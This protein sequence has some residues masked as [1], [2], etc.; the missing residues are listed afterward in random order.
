MKNNDSWQ[1]KVAIVT[2][3]SAG[4]GK[5]T[6]LALAERG[7]KV[8]ITGRNAEKLKETASASTSIATLLADS[9]DPATCALII[10]TALNHWGR[11]DLIVNNAGAGHPMPTASYDAELIAKMCAVNIT[12]PSLMVKEGQAA[13]RETKGAIVNIALPY[14]ET[15]HRSLPITRQPRPHW[16]I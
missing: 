7:A 15:H 9:A 1:D 4:I 16:S 14:P 13:L 3:G 11:L 10:K 12:T 2:G 8:L 5:A 6:A